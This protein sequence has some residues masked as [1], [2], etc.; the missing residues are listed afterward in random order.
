MSPNSSMNL[1]ARSPGSAEPP[2]RR[3][4]ATRCRTSSASPRGSSMIRCTITGT[5]DERVGAV[6]RDLA[7]GV[8]GVELA[9]QH[10]GR[11][12][13]QPER[14]VGEAPG[15]EQRRGDVACLARLQRDPRQQRDRRAD[16]LGLRAGGA[17]RRAGGARGEDRRRGPSLSGGTGGSSVAAP[18]SAPRASGR[19]ASSE[20]CQ[21]MKRLRRL[22][23]SSS[24]SV[25]SSS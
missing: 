25:N 9:L 1:V 19:R 11:A 16:R 24:S 5:I 6:A 18:R 3:P 12:E 4:S 14:E 21:A 23:A 20:S 13:Q 17:L 7:R 22:P 2:R 15:V 8:L 10:V